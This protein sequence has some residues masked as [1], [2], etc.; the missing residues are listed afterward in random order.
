MGF[1]LS[2][3]QLASPAFESGGAIPTK[4]GTYGDNVSPPLGGPT[5]EGS[6][7]FRC[8][9][10]IPTRHS[11]LPTAATGSCTGCSRRSSRRSPTS[12]EDRPGSRRMQSDR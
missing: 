9:C 3:M 12:T 11:P 2:D 5:R 4:Y 10:M 6:R 8:L 7:S 1:A